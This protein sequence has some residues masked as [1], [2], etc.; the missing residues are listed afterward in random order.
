MHTL[1]LPETFKASQSLPTEWLKVLPLQQQADAKAL[2]ALQ[3]KIINLDHAILPI[4]QKIERAEVLRCAVVPLLE[5][6]MLLFS[7]KAV[8]QTATEHALFVLN[9][10][11]LKHLMLIYLRALGALLRKNNRALLELALH[12]AVLLNRQWQ[13]QFFVSQRM[14][15]KESVA[16]L[17]YCLNF[18]KAHQLLHAELNDAAFVQLG[19]S[20]VGGQIAWALLMIA[21]RPLRLNLNECK[22]T[23]RIAAR[24]REM[25]TFDFQKQHDGAVSFSELYAQT[26]TESQLCWVDFSF[27]LKKIN[28]RMAALNRGLTPAQ[29]KFGS[30]LNAFQCKNLLQVLK[31]RL[32]QMMS[33]PHIPPQD[34]RAQQTAFYMHV[35]K[36]YPALEQ[37]KHPSFETWLQLD[38]FCWR[39]AQQEGARH[40]SPHLVLTD[41]PLRLG[42]L[43]ALC[44][45]AFGGLFAYVEWFSK[46]VEFGHYEDN[47]QRHPI[48]FVPDIQ[49][50]VLVAF[51]N[52]LTLHQTYVLSGCSQPSFTPLECLEHGANFYRYRVQ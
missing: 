46:H 50:E 26:P 40:F 32:A 42:M 4:E 34:I 45:D 30:Y 10:N 1:R 5:R 25:I 52:P 51:E 44:E 33:F 27:V 8:P 14:I 3:Q 36:D 12:R 39:D 31:Q 11:T 2:F 6:A 43:S 41:S 21:A 7:H 29:I 47:N 13:W 48:F 37:A 9:A 18:G 49:N 23:Q 22:V 38:N 16:Y 24:W 15:H 35:F 17:L 28:S 19:K 20:S